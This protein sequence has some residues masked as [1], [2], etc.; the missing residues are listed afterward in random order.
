[1]GVG[2]W[3]GAGAYNKWKKGNRLTRGLAQCY[4]CNDGHREGQQG[5]SKDCLGKSCALY[6]WMPYRS[7]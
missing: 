6:Q 3:K 2:G 5:K 1:M 7:K 4:D